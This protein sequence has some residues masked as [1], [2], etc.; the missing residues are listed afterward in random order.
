MP[1]SDINKK[2]KF[3][4]GTRPDKVW[5][6]NSKRPYIAISFSAQNISMLILLFLNGVNNPVK[7]KI[8]D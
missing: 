5:C 7:L 3:V 2:I 4:K 6:A 1:K 8:M